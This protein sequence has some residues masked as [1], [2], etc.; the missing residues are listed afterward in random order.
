MSPLHIICI[1]ELDFISAQY[2]MILNGFVQTAFILLITPLNF[3]LSI[4]VLELFGVL[5]NSTSD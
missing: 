5:H 2:P 1:S 4:K 3:N